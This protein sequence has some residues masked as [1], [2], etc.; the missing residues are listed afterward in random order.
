MRLGDNFFFFFFFLIFSIVSTQSYAHVRECENILFSGLS[1][2][3][4]GCFVKKATVNTRLKTRIVL[5]T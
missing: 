1:A 2:G 5:R 3:H 4:R